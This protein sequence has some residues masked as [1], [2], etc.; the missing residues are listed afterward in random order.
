MVECM[1]IINDFK[2]SHFPFTCTTNV[3]TV[4][5]DTLFICYVV[6]FKIFQCWL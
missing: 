6:M 2:N 1:K 4:Y 3:S 5:H